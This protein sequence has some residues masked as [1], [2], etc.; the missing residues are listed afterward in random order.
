MN[1]LGLSYFI[2]I[3]SIRPEISI[4]S[5]SFNQARKESTIFLKGL[6]LTHFNL[7]LA[8]INN[9]SYFSHS[10]SRFDSGDCY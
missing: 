6:K 1:Y 4:Y 10:C 5:D 9:S 7:I 3:Q 2:K 8:K